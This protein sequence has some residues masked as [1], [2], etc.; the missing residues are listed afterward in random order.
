MFPRIILIFNTNMLKIT[1]TQIQFA[2]T[3][4]IALNFSYFT[5]N[6]LDSMLIFT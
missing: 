4:Y 1:Y 3:N 5:Y 6:D 2:N